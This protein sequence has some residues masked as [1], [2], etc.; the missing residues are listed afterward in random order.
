MT[1]DPYAA[2]NVPPDELERPV[3]LGDLRR[4]GRWWF[5]VPSLGIVLALAILVATHDLR[6]EPYVW[7]L[8]ASAAFVAVVGAGV[9]H[10][11]GAF[12]RSA[13]GP[14]YLALAAL[15]GAIWSVAAALTITAYA[16][17]HSTHFPGLWRVDRLVGRSATNCLFFVPW[18][19]LLATSLR[20]HY[21]HRP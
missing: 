8:L 1:N 16:D 9:G 7:G 2:P 15:L 17:F 6:E 4:R 13:S 14:R 11:C 5:A 12:A 3:P 19:L 18:T 20:A 21:R 10:A